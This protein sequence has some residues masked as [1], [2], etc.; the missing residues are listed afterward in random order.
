MM[1]CQPFGYRSRRTTDADE[2]D[3]LPADGTGTFDGIFLTGILAVL[4]ARF[5][6]APRTIQT[7]KAGSTGRVGNAGEDCGE[8]VR[9]RPA[10]KMEKF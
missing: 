2:P 10:A 3:A 1:P 9:N 8:V 5:Y 6:A 4:P 7:G